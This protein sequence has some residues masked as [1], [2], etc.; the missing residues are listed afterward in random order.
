MKYIKTKWAQLRASQQGNV[1]IM[2]AICIFV[3]LAGVGAA[4]DLNILTRSKEKVIDMADA[5]ALTAAI[6]ARETPDIR[7]A[8]ADSFFEKNRDAAD[9]VDVLDDMSIVFDDA[10]KEVNV[11]VSADVDYQFMN[12]FGF[13]DTIVSASV[14]ATYAITNVPPASIAFAFDTSGSMGQFTPDGRTRIEALREATDALFVA[15]FEEA[16]NT[17]LLEDA[18]RTGFSTYNTEIVIQ[19]RM[20]DGFL[21][22]IDTVENDP[23]FMA[24]GGTNSRPSVLFGLSELLSE[25]QASNDPNWSGFLIFMTDGNNNQAV[26]DDQT[27]AL[28][29]EARALN[30]TVFTVAFF[31]PQNGQDLLRACAT[32]EAHYFETDT[33]EELSA[34]FRR[35]GRELGESTV[36]LSK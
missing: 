9:G 21:H 22:V 28:C 6:A 26:W 4:I 30:Y 20:R 10:T 24:D 31:A 23:L 16:E 5:V 32:S 19:A 29:D 17:A 15:M 11:I 13:A 1:A 34:S 36:R 25:E 18:L 7:E 14:R 27:L 8:V 3:V 12:I 2:A 35:I 33:T